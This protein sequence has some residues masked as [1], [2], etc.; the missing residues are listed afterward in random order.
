MYSVSF[1]DRLNKFNNYVVIVYAM[2][3]I[4]SSTIVA[5]FCGAWIERL[6]VVIGI[7]ILGLYL[8]NIFTDKKIA[9]KNVLLENIIAIVYL[10]F[11]A[12]TLYKL[13]LDYSTLRTIFFETVYLLCIS[14]Y[15]LGNVENMKCI[16]KYLIGINLILNI[17]NLVMFFAL[18]QVPSL[19][20]SAIKYTFLNTDTN[21][22]YSALYPNP[23]T[24]GIMTTFSILCAFILYRKT[25]T[26]SLVY[27][28][29]YLVI[30]LISIYISGCR[31]AEIALLVTLLAYI[32]I[33]LLHINK[34][35]LIVGLCLISSIIFVAGISG[36]I[37]SQYD[38]DIMYISE[39]EIKLDNLSTGRYMIWKSGYFAHREKL[40]SGVGSLHNEIK[41]RDGYV[42]NHF[43][44][45]HTDL[46]EH[47]RLKLGPHNGYIGMIWCT[48]VVGAL[49]FFLALLQKIKMAKS[50]EN[51]NW[52]LAVIFIF[53]VNLFETMFIISRFFLV[54]YLFLILAMD[55][56]S[57]TSAEGSSIE[58]PENIAD[59]DSIKKSIECTQE[60]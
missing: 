57:E 35:K 26:Y 52:Y 30:S 18:N 33:K 28:A 60:V 39:T 37:S 11:R 47:N 56:D 29:I 6:E 15:I 7:A 14:R 50:L 16:F 3:F 55:D 24:M 51:G 10:C 53:I 31:A 22:I 23:N 36:Y 1:N 43:K 41:Q 49:L 5:K 38:R 13:H 54:L 32:I 42:V 8:I 34:L 12:Y 4:A 19:Y 21:Y 46:G 25:E 17:A 48:G 44:E 45:N 9:L 58:N 40:L 20:K 59:S 2:L 27:R